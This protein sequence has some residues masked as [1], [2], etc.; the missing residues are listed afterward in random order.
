MGIDGNW[1]GAWRVDGRPITN[2]EMWMLS[3]F[4][5]QAREQRNAEA[6]QENPRQAETPGDERPGGEEESS[7]DV[8]RPTSE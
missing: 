4:S 1:D 8:Q 3:N 6:I 2:V 5:R 7:S